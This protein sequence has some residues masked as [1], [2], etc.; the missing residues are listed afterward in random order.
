MI[1]LKHTSHQMG[2]TSISCSLEEFGVNIIRFLEL[3]IYNLQV[4]DFII[5]HALGVDFL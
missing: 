2:S 1:V 5:M 4:Q 3:V